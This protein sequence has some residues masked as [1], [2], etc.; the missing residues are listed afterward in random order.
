MKIYKMKFLLFGMLFLVPAI[1]NA[2]TEDI[3]KKSSINREDEIFVVV[4]QYPEFPGGEE[5]RKEFLLSHIVYPKQARERKIEGKVI[6]GF[7]VEK[8]GSITN[9]KVIKSAHPLL[10]AEAVRVT[11]LMPKWIP[12]KERGKAVRVQYTAPITYSL[13]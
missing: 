3:S 6:V 4:E 7:I 13:N 9:V 12:G 1:L 8:D 10:D 2:Q 5:A 11:K